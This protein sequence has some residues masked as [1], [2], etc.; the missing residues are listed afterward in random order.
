MKKTQQR[1]MPR[2]LVQLGLLTAALVS[3]GVVHA[4]MSSAAVR[5]HI[6]AA[7]AAVP[8]GTE[9]VAVNKAT[10]AIARTKTLSD[11]SYV[12][13]GLNPGRYEVRV[14][15]AT[16]G[17]TVDLVV[18]E[19]ASLD[20]VAAGEQLDRVTVQ[21][22]AQRQGVVS[23]EV[24]TNVSTKMIEN[25]PQA[26]RNF[27]SSVDL[28]P[29]VRFN[30]DAS[31][32]TRIQSGA[33]GVDSVNVYI[34]GVGHKNNILRGGLSGQDTSQGNPFP[35]SAI[36]EYKVLTQNYKAEFDQ[37]S[38]A[39]ISAVTKSGT[40]EFH[41][42][43]YY[44][45][46]G[47]N[48]VADSPLDKQNAANGIPRPSFTQTEEGFS[49]GGPIKQD[50]LQFF[51]AYDGKKID[52]PG[53]VKWGIPTSDLPSTGGVIPQ[54]LSEQGAYVPTFNEN[55][56]F[57]KLTALLSDEQTL[58]FSFTVRREKSYS[59]NGNDFAQST[60]INNVNNETRFDLKHEWTR[61]PWLNEARIGHEDEL[62]QPQSDS[63]SPQVDYKYSPT[64]MLNNTQDILFDGGSPNAQ[65]RGQKGT[66]LKDDLTYTGL[67]GHVIKGGAQFKAM[68]YD[69]SGTAFRV[70]AVQAVVNNTTGIPYYANGL[71][72]GTNISNNG[73]SSDQCT[74]SKAI[75]AVSVNL[76]NN[77]FG[78]YLQDDWNVT[79]QLQLNLGARW[80]YESNMLDNNYVTPADRVAALMGIDGRTIPGPN[81][82][83][84]APAG[85]TYAQSLAKG[86]INISDFISN[87]SSRKPYTGALAP[88]LGA[89][90]DVFSD[91][92]T[93]V[94]GGWG[95]S[96]DRK[97]ANNALDELQKNQQ[98]GGE[99]WL[100]NNN[101]KMPFADQFSLGLR[102]AVGVWNV[103]ATVSH[104][105]AKNQFVWYGGNR[106]PNGGWG[107]Q[108]PTDP[109]WGGP[110]GYS[111]LV[112]GDFVARNRSTSLVLKA[113]K[114]YTL[115]SGW[116]L[117]AAYTYTHAETTMTNWDDDIFDWTYGKS[118]YGFHPSTLAERNRLVVGAFTDRALPW[119][120][121]LSGK[122]TLGSGQ[123]RRLTNCSAGF[124]ACVS[125][126]G[127]SNAFRQVDMGLSKSFK[128][129]YGQFAIRGDVLNL[130][131]W[132][133]WGYYDDW[134]GGPSTPPKNYLGGDNADLGAKTG[135]RGNMRT[136]KLTAS[137]SF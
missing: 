61:G 3:G 135:L 46:T 74:I 29:G 36:A 68:E 99:I 123:P 34:D 56:L 9:V 38:S 137:Y 59:T 50:T 66:Y 92:A 131:N 100:I 104:V 73:L 88:R 112:L 84:V 17:V 62:W 67:A 107:N 12:L 87:G 91:K 83:I 70:D 120:L 78:I 32:N 77:Q 30:T 69:L 18:G 8:A 11:G 117:T 16:Q 129:P 76:K 48:W 101:F 64:N 81:G 1:H 53:I 58:D 103:D 85:Q 134:V 94:Y 96:Y 124:N 2:H 121:G 97:M 31:G 79:R 4:Q 113:E 111:T 126:E 133:N 93:V 125:T 54:L 80:D 86:G 13:V 47:S 35:Q 22:S 23:S 21:G 19:T 44:D 98:P 106:D 136:F 118:T 40:N 71:C 63:T 132:A 110:N 105:D 24:G 122:L 25:L 28:A 15:A 65:N 41:G 42:D 14:G 130:F 109:L 26:T 57:G 115:E 82:N 6:S 39:A 33:Q 20:M 5:G 119:G 51:L 116:S 45:R 128:L 10:G 127:N 55:L 72:T 114:P 27:L 95:R 52:R 7:G 75:P 89:S 90:Y 37:V 49:L 108:S 43:A 102:Q 60:A